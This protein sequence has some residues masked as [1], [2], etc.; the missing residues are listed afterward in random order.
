MFEANFYPK[1]VYDKME[2]M[3]K[4]EVESKEITSAEVKQR[5]K[6]FLRIINLLPN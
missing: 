6:E 1:E 3:T 5:E 2:N 4:T